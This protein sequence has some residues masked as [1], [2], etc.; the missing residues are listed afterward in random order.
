MFLM[1][2]GTATLVAQ[3]FWGRGGRLAAPPRTRL[4]E[5]NG[6]ID[7]G[8]TF[9][10]LAYIQVR[11]EAQGTGWSTDYPNAEHNFM[12]RISQLTNV[13]ISLR[14]NGEP[15]YTVVTPMDSALFQCPFLFAS[16]V[17][18]AAF[19]TEE[20][21]RMNAY[22]RKGGFLWVDDF[23]GDYA[24]ENWTRELQKI[25]PGAEVID[26]PLDHKLF[27]A[28]YHVQ[29]I[30]QVPSIQFW[31]RNG[32]ATSERGQESA[33][34]HLRAALDD[35]GRIAVLMSHNTDIADGWEREGE[36]DEFF[37]RFSPDTYALG[38]NIAVWAMSH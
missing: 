33:V 36:D 22:L 15:G 20:V 2:A 25:L 8:F 13:D 17:G 37:A 6:G 18:T 4:P 14:P 29:R 30:P 34:P 19:D 1:L 28:L 35:K 24:W 9:C 16:D 12:T 10:R 11:R 31:R 3:E 27:A 7:R 26:L 32:G 5:W 23:W 38:I 21:E